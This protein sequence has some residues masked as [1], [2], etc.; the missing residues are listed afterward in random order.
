MNAPHFHLILNHVPTVGTAI[1]LGLLLLSLLRRQEALRRVSLE[2]FY[3]LALLTLPTYLSG[4]AT[5]LQLENLPDVSVEAIHKHHDGAVVAFALML[6]TGLASWLGLWQWRRTSRPSGL[7]T[8][9]V[10]VLALLTLTTMAGTATMGGEIR[11]PEMM[12]E[13]AEPTAGPTWITAAYL[14]SLVTDH[15]W[16]WPSF[17]ALHFIGLWLLFGVVL[18]VN[19]RMLGMMK[20]A[21][22]SSLHRMLPW[23]VLGLGINVVTG[24]MWVIATPEQYMTNVS[25]FWKIGFLLL[26]GINLL[27]VTAFDEPWQVGAGEEASWGN[28][29]IAFSAIASWV[30]VMY[31]G[32]MLPFLGNAF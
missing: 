9:I 15:T 25:F 12:V 26:A 5:G 13:G 10:L 28:K 8:G 2:V 17:E 4:V 16:L 32:R 21:S 14:Q 6:M 22:F 29:A 3:V 27:Y 20:A 23:A 19:L 11:H 30:C 18:L 7:N 31:F 24:M 1:A